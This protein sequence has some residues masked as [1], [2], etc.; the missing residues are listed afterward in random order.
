MLFENKP[1]K[2]IF[3]AY[4]FLIRCRIIFRRLSQAIDSLIEDCPLLRNEKELIVNGLS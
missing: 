4:C 1:G 3:R 2:V